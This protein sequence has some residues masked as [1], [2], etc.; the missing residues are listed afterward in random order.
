[1]KAGGLCRSRSEPFTRSPRSYQKSSESLRKIISFIVECLGC[2]VDRHE[3]KEKS[4]AN[5]CL[6]KRLGPCADFTGSC[7]G[8]ELQQ[9]IASKLPM[10]P[11]RAD[12]EGLQ[13]QRL[14]GNE[15]ALRGDRWASIGSDETF[16]SAQTLGG[17]EVE[18]YNC[19]RSCSA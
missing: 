1:M 8:G 19:K 18:G 4:S 5:D 17:G 6:R 10:Q 14:C 11:R 3:I 9:K 16:A 15:D 7:E 2:I 12:T 13:F